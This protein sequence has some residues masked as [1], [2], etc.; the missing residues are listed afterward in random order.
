MQQYGG[1][2]VA[3]GEQGYWDFGYVR[4]EDRTAEEVKA[5]QIARQSIL[6]SLPIRSWQLDEPRYAL[7]QCAKRVTG[8]FLKY[9]RQITGSCVG[10]GGGNMLKTLIFVEIDQGDM[11]EYLDI[12]WLYT[13]GKSRQRGGLR[14]RGEGSF[15]SAWA[16]AITKDGIF[17]AKNGQGLPDFKDEKGWQVLTQSLEM[18]WS[19][20]AAIPDWAN[21]LAKEHLVKKVAKIN[22]A[23]EL[24]AAIRNG[25]PATQAS[26]FG[27]RDMVPNPVGDPPVRLATWD[28]SWAH[29]TYFDEVW[30]HP[31]HGL[32]FRYGNNWGADAH[33][34]P[35]AGEPAG[36]FYIK[37]DTVDR[38]CRGNE[39][40]AF[41]MWDGFPVKDYDLSYVY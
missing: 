16:E 13:Y 36:G 10:A 24:A 3:K 39:V 1:K 7:W 15:G 37:A 21:Q 33:G 28:G 26:M 11:E 17:A 38:I 18:Q 19:D 40:F 23:N 41:S 8:S 4:P 20:G 9:I 29:Q 31:S 30:D 34:T 6:S 35:T 27:I 22:N 32:I 12:W 14:G 25:Y 5:D 2:L